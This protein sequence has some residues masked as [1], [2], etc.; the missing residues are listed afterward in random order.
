MKGIVFTEFLEMVED[1]FGFD[2]A[3]DIIQQAQLPS[4]GVYTAVGTY[5]YTEMVSLVVNLSKAT[6][7]AVPDLLKA[8]GQHLFGRFVIGYGHFF[9]QV[10]DTFAFLSRI[11]NYIHVEV[12]KLY[13]DAELPRFDISQPEADRLEMLYRSSR[14]LADF[15]EGLLMGCIAHFQENIHIEREN[16]K[17]DQTEVRFSL[18]RTH[19]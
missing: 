18:I 8:Y 1:R 9:A 4:G 15:G 7:I 19:A 12:R 17:P 6:G 5:E 3:D 10:P 2:V 14:G 13:P 11:D 16:L